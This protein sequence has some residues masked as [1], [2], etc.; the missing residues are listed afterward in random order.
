MSMDCRGA[1]EGGPR[2]FTIWRVSMGQRGPW[3]PVMAPAL[4]LPVLL[5]ACGGNAT[6]TPNPAAT[7]GAIASGT[8]L[9]GVPSQDDLK[10]SSM[11]TNWRS[12]R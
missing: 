11:T 1:M 10:S 7:S 8:Y 9:A 2:M 12:G 4:T 3:T 5:T 6:E